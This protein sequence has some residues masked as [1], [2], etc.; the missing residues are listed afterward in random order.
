M[1]QG[2]GDAGRSYKRPTQQRYLEVVENILLKATCMD[3]LLKAD[4]KP[5]MQYKKKRVVTQ[6]V[7]SCFFKLFF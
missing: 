4:H 2:R 5:L 7:K 6:A 1:R 3:E